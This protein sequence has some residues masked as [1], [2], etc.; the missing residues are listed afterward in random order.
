[1]GLG[2]ILGGTSRSTTGACRRG[3]VGADLVITK[4]VFVAFAFSSNSR[5]VGGRGGS[6]ASPKAGGNFLCDSTDE[7]LVTEEAVWP[8]DIPDIVELNDKVDSFDPRRTNCVD[9]FRGGRA[10]ES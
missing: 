10:G 9:V 5:R 1:M 2:G 7:A 6:F 4:G 8:N 3:T